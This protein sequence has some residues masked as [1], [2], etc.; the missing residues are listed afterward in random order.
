MTNGPSVVTIDKPLTLK[1]RD[2]LRSTEKGSPKFKKP[3]N[4]SFHSLSVVIEFLLCNNCDEVV[5]VQIDGDNPIF[6]PECRTVDNFSEVEDE[7]C[8]NC[9]GSGEGYT[10]GSKCSVCGGSGVLEHNC[11]EEYEESEE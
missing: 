10:D 4:F 9:N 1:E 6:C 7:L 11:E 2:E 8:S 3:K 5:E